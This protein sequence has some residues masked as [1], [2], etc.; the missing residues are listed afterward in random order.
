MHRQTLKSVQVIEATASKT[1]KNKRKQRQNKMISE[2][3]NEN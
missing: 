2:K 1:T 3:V